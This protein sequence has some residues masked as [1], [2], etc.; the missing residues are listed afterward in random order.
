MNSVL[1]TFMAIA[2][3][4]IVAFGILTTVYLMRPEWLGLEQPPTADS[5]QKQPTT[6]TLEIAGY[7]ALV[8][9]RDSL[10]KALGKVSDTASKA[11]ANYTAAIRDVETLKQRM[12]LQDKEYTQRQDSIVKF[13]FTLFAKM[14]DKAAPK[15]VAKILAE[16]D[17][18]D[19]AFVLKTMKPKMAAKVLENLSPEQ[20][21]A[22][23]VL[24]ASQPVR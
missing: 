11:Q 14:Y 24:S 19:A 21:A 13:N 9:E 8:K 2:V 10:K 4:I 18:R 17:E 23:M 6:M 1:Q 3:V 7:K 15:E 16:L 5:V 12:S 22:I 20:A